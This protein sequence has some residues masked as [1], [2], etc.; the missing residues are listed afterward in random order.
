MQPRNWKEEHL[1]ESELDCGAAQSDAT[2]VADLDPTAASAKQSR[3]DV[4][5]AVTYDEEEDAA[6]EAALL[7]A[8]AGAAQPKAPEGFM[9]SLLSTVKTSIVGKEALSADDVANAVGV[10]Q[11]RLQVCVGAACCNPLQL[12]APGWARRGKP[13][14]VHGALPRIINGS[15]TLQVVQ[16]SQTPCQPLHAVKNLHVRWEQAL[17]VPPSLPDSAQIFEFPLL[18]GTGP[19]GLPPMHDG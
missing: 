8:K 2:A 17:W 7:G 9:G 12:N 16:R 19:N 11:K 1:D 18:P 4:D 6:L 3:M 14:A 13:V 15:A 5:E 10:L